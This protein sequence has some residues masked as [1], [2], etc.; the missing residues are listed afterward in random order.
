MDTG[1]GGFRDAVRP[2]GEQVNSGAAH[3]LL[4]KVMVSLRQLRPGPRNG[5]AT[6]VRSSF[7][8][9]LSFVEDTIMANI[10]C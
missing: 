6:S 5:G 2:V 4:L 1:E 7:I 3:S 9:F 10:S 8:I